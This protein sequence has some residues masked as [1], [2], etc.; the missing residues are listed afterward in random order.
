MMIYKKLVKEN[1]FLDM[2]KWK[3]KKDGGR[4]TLQCRLLNF[5]YYF[6]KGQKGYN[7]GR[8]GGCGGLTEEIYKVI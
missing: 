3:T 6:T 4:G 5:K 8:K 7:G 1:V 2:K